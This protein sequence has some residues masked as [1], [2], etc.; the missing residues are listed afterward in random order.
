MEKRANILIVDDNISLAKTM[1]LILKRKGYEAT[2]APD[3][4]VAIERV[5]ERPFDLI[6]MDIKM[7]LM[8]GVQIYRKI[9]KIRPEIIVIMMTAYAV[10]NLVAEALKEGAYGIIYKPLDIEKMISLIEKSRKKK[11]GALILVVDDDPGTCMTLK[12]I[13]LKKGYRVGIAHDGEKAITMAREKTHDIIFIDLKLPTINGLEVYLKI[14]EID[15][16]L[17]AIMMTGY[18]K[19]M[20]DL[21]EEALNNNAYACIYK[22]LDIE[23]LLMLIEEIW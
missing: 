10:E 11:Q 13:F 9:K 8:D 14:K 1:S 6:F 5:K 16:K 23:K 15:P 4:P 22:P 2:T 12:N 20:T 3:G 17:V 19:E 7:P 21:V 18:R